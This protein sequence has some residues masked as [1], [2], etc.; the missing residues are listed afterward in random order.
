MVPWGFRNNQ[1][2]RRKQTSHYALHKQ[3][4]APRIMALDV[5]AEVVHPNTG[6]VSHDISS[7]LDAGE[8]AAVMGR[9]DLR[10]VNGHN[11]RETSDSHSR[12]DTAYDQGG[13]SICPCL[14]SSSDHEDN[15]SVKDRLPPSND[16]SYAPHYER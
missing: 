11:R 12:N 16:V 8:L 10:L 5:T 14:H 4:Q 15:R 6:S 3:W 13:H 2:A 1:R 7:K 9:R